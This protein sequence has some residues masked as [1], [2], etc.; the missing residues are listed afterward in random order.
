MALVR[1]ESYLP[2]KLVARLEDISKLEPGGLN[3]LI[4][5]VLESYVKAK[6]EGRV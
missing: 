3:G 2:A 5:H 6:E 4:K 1:L